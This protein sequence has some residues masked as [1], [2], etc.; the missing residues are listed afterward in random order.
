MEQVGVNIFG[1]EPAIE[2]RF[3]QP[4]A[5]IALRRTPASPPALRQVARL[6]RHARATLRPFGSR[7]TGRL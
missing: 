1:N 7:L 3:Y 4:L 5:A 2:L 6:F